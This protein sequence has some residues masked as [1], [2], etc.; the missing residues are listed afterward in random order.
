MKTPILLAGLLFAVASSTQAQVPG[1][2]ANV[3]FNFTLSFS[4][5]GTVMKSEETGKA[6][7]GK[8][9]FG[10]PLGGPAFWN[11]WALPKRNK[12]AEVV[13]LERHEEYIS[14]IGTRKYGNKEFLMD[15]DDAGLLPDDETGSGIAG[16]TVVQVTGTFLN[17]EEEPHPGAD[18]F[19]A[20]H[21]KRN[22]SVLLTGE[23]ISRDYR[24]RNGAA[25]NWNYK[26]V[27]KQDFVKTT[28]ST[29]MTDNGNLKSVHRYVMDFSDLLDA[30]DDTGSAYQFQGIHTNAMK[31]T[32]VRTGDSEK[33]EAVVYQCGPGKLDKVSGTGPFYGENESDRE[34][35]EGSL[36]IAAGK[37]HANISERFPDAAQELF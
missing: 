19:Y 20:V 31:L 12:D 13:S 28:S 17:D 7:T 33:P 16:W 10:D 3:T 15:L 5:E 6:I 29:T 22:L 32:K 23:V 26:R 30:G 1:S 2:V 27:T 35:L 8:D 37:V 11:S 24:A 21:A 18:F 34:V 9:E 4:K 36:S 25:E 14:K